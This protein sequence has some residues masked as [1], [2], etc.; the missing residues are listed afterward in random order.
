MGKLVNQFFLISKI[1]IR[2][3]SFVLKGLVEVEIKR[4]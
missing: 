1:K 4:F 2:K 3:V